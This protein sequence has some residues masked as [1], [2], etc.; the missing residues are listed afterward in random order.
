MIVSLSYLPGSTKDLAT[1]LCLH[2][3]YMPC[4]RSSIVVSVIEKSLQ[5]VMTLATSSFEQIPCVA[6][7][8]EDNEGPDKPAGIVVAAP[9]LWYA[10]QF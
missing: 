2:S 7:K 5:D 1:L 9:R 4:E 10:H 3:R 8:C 6:I